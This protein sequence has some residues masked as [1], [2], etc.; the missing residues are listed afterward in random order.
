[1]SF[2]GNSSSTGHAAVSRGCWCGLRDVC[3]PQAETRSPVTGPAP[4][5]PSRLAVSTEPSEGD[6]LMGNA[7]V[8]DGRS[9]RGCRSGRADVRRGLV[10][11]QG[12]VASGGISHGQ[13]TQLLGSRQELFPSHLSAPCACLSSS[14]PDV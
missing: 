2:V 14:P 3:P 13:H 11:G 4:C 7:A 12:R 9:G 8:L 1:M 5:A 10:D 6:E